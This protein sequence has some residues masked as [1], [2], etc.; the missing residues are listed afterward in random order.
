[1]L[2]GQ[3]RAVARRWVDAEASGLPGFAGAFYHGSTNWLPDDAPLPPNSDLDLMIVLADDYPLMKPG[4]F[5]YRGV[6][7]E[8]SSLSSAELR[9]PDLVLGQSH[10]AGSF[11][12]PGI[13]AD[14]TGRLTT[15]Q[16]AVSRDYAKRH[17][18]R[19]RCE[20]A[21]DKV[22][23]NLQSLRE[24]NPFHDQVAAWLFATGVTTHVLL[25]AGLE[26]PTVRRRYVAVRELLNVYDHASFYEPLLELLGAAH[27][28]RARV[29]QH[30]AALATA[31]DAA[32]GVI[33]TPFPF[34]ADLTAQAR[35]IA[36][37]GSRALIER[38]DHRE[39]IFWMVATYSRCQKMFHHDAPEELQDRFTDGYRLLLDDLGISSS[40]ALQERGE[41]VQGFLPQ[42]WAV[43]EAI[44]AAN[45]AIEA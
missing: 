10:L 42:V 22:L 2:V 28:S 15:F 29:T 3:A 8:V 24:A 11:R 30:L 43:A 16:A 21:R 34:A 25:V 20:H 32:I 39:A 6:L 5:S 45:P 33:K 26:N 37:D 17:W 12:T 14:P 44:M 19:R 18:V 35:P 41:Q 1:M 7:L 23:Q 9:S 38:G 36:I 27:L 4:K 31:F 40:A 13:I